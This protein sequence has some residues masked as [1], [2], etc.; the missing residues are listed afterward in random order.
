MREKRSKFVSGDS[1]PVSLNSGCS[2]FKNENSTH[3][4]PWG[5]VYVQMVVLLKE[6]TDEQ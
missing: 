2:S 5:A 1:V 3:A 4:G 6:R